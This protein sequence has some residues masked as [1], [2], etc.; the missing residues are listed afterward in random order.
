M[1]SDP[2]LGEHARPSR[3]FRRPADCALASSALHPTLK[4]ENNV[5]RPPPHSR[6]SKAAVEPWNKLRERRSSER[7]SEESFLF[8]ARS[9]GVVYRVTT[10]FRRL[11][12]LVMV[13]RRGEGVAGR[14]VFVGGR[15][16][17]YDGCDAHIRHFEQY[18]VIFI[19]FFHGLPPPLPHLRQYFQLLRCL[20]HLDVNEC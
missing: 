16:S 1:W 9:S 20:S 6:K 5:C 2:G 12:C 10:S 14:K 15:E 11:F 18:S 13:S 3:S 7:A 8:L 4:H 19:C 17:I